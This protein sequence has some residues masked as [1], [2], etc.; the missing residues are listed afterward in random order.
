MQADTYP[1]LPVASSAD[2]K[3]DRSGDVSAPLSQ[4]G[5]YNVAPLCPQ[6]MHGAERRSR[7][8]DVSAP[9]RMISGAGAL[10]SCA[11]PASV[12]SELTAN[13]LARGLTERNLNG[14]P[15]LFGLRHRTCCIQKMPNSDQLQRRGKL[16]DSS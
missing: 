13:G 14:L 8:L 16:K 15:S 5:V 10:A 2:Q 4:F 7:S 6:Q 12:R 1:L 9:Q 11:R 3:P